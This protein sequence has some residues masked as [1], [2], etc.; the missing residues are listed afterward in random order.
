MSRESDARSGTDSQH[1]ASLTRRALLAGASIVGMA[2]L[3]GIG[4]ASEGSD[5]LG[6]MAATQES[7]D[8]PWAKKEHDHS[9][10]YGTA[11]HLGKAAPVDS[12][13][14]RRI[15][16]DEFRQPLQY[17]I[18]RDGDQPVALN[19]NTETEEF[20]DTDDA[21]V[22][23][24]AVDAL[25]AQSRH[26]G[27]GRIVFAPAH[28][29]IATPID[30]PQNYGDVVFEAHDNRGKGFWNSGGA[31]FDVSFDFDKP[32]PKPIFRTQETANG[33]LSAYGVTFKGLKF[34][35]GGRAS[36]LVDLPDADTVQ[37]SNCN[38]RSAAR[39][40]VRMYAS[41][42]LDIPRVGLPGKL[43]FVGC[44]F[45]KAGRDHIRVVDT[46][47]NRYSG[48]MFNPVQRNHIYIESSNKQRIYGNEFNHANR[49]DHTTAAHVW[50]AGDSERKTHDVVA[51]NNI[52]VGQSDHDGFH[53]ADEYVY[54]NSFVGN[55]VAGTHR[56]VV[57]RKSPQT[58]HA[59]NGFDEDVSASNFQV[60]KSNPLLRLTDDEGEEFRIVKRDGGTANIFADSVISQYVAGEKLTD[61]QADGDFSLVKPG[62]GIV[63]KT[64]DGSAQYRIG[65][66]NEG[67]VTS[68]QV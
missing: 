8:T 7:E 31:V 12:I 14:T 11:T 2:G 47:Q 45:A 27:T 5:E 36:P 56:S 62:K 59:F 4:T 9:G 6:G 25:P 19:G 33:D 66:D 15:S 68:E 61:L 22:I 52:L 37:F 46:T 18:Y 50:L 1:H 39:D 65:I 24:Q 21:T 28:Y 34:M 26:D 67:N 55:V 10:E 64:P 48:N 16:I 17:L 29:R 44:E 60:D 57:A 53:E 51:T 41:D 35:G 42:G 13:N 30:I 32:E 20:V 43:E 38:F 23:Q 49:G 3:T 58:Q 54:R 63:L 40:N